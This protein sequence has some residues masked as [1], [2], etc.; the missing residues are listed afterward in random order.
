MRR[1]Y[2]RTRV[3]V[4]R[5]VRRTSEGKV[6]DAAFVHDRSLCA[7]YLAHAEESPLAEHAPERVRA[8][9]FEADAGARDQVFD[10]V[11]DQ[12]LS[13]RRLVRDPHAYL[14]RDARD[15][16][17]YNVAL[18]R[19]EARSHLDAEAR[20]VLDNRVRAS[21]RARRA[22]E[23]RERAVADHVSL[24]PAEPLDLLAHVRAQA[25]Q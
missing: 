21:A 7:A 1:F 22:V 20:G 17:A 24:A 14:R 9:V 2:S 3:L 15:L 19:V 4:H 5:R 11:R 8:S 25:L 16:A 12:D 23:Y 18:A 13:G 10:R 6:S